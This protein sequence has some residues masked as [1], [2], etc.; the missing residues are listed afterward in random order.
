MSLVG[1]HVPREAT[2]AE[3]SRWKGVRSFK[4]QKAGQWLMCGEQ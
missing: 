1:Q 3:A 4:E 2:Q